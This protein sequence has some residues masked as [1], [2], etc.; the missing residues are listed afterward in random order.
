MSGGYNPNSG[1]QY[2]N[3]PPP[4]HSPQS[5]QT[6]NQQSQYS[7]P[8]PHGHPQGYPQ[9]AP[10]KAFFAPPKQ[11]KTPQL[12]QPKDHDDI[13]QTPKWNDVWA[14]I[15]FYVHLGGFFGLFGWCI[16][17]A[18]ERDFF[19]GFTVFRT[20]IDLF[21]VAWP[22][23]M[24]AATMIN[25]IGIFALFH[26]HPKGSIIF[27]FWA[28]VGLSIA[29][30]IL[31]IVQG[32]TAGIVSGCCVLVIALVMAI[33]FFVWRK[34]IPLTVLI[35]E[36]VTGV[37]SQYPAVIGASLLSG[38]ALSAYTLL[39]ILT[40]GILMELFG[41][42]IIKDAAFYGLGLYALF[43][44]YWT[45][46]VGT[47]IVHT[48]TAGVMATFYFVTGSGHTV[49]NPTLA[50]AKRTLTYSFGSV[51]FGSL[52]VAL[53][54]TLRAVLKSSTNKRGLA[55]ALADCFLSI[56]EGIAEYFNYYAYIYVAIYGTSYL[57][58]AHTTWVMIKSR[59]IE[60]IIN[61]NL[62]STCVGMFCFLN[63]FLLTF[64]TAITYL[65]FKAS[66]EYFFIGVQCF[67]TFFISL[68]ITIQILDVIG[69]AS[70][71]TFVCLAE[72]P[73]ALQRTK[74]QLYSKFEQTYPRVFAILYA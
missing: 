47:N 22:V 25:C 48:I 46:Q 50:S 9:Q 2:Y 72:D 28:N 18:I 8:P 37:I 1:N 6:R 17:Y 70:S 58:S 69:S 67:L 38:L 52:L 7:P 55:G 66:R 24:L 74:P 29:L 64:L 30:G 65:V 61:D 59:G 19:T 4:P 39:F 5:P 56:I 21:D 43:S 41:Y 49:K 42:N 15:L 44:F 10:E 36:T 27:A 63:S 32:G 54:Q 40:Q 60:A 20:P 23:V 12:H 68:A 53:I 62:I 26:Y 71:T 33:L 45:S 11:Q 51:A 14:L 35:L 16:K 34:H 73:A 57:D 13:F 31:I 3:Y